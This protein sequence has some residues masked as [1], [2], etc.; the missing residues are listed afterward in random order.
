MGIAVILAATFVTTSA[1]HPAQLVQRFAWTQLLI[2]LVAGGCF[3][4]WRVAQFPKSR[5]A[6]FYL[7][8]PA[9]DWQ[10]V[11]AQIV[12]GVFRATLLVL[13][14]LPFVAGMRGAGWIGV[15]E[16]IRMIRESTA[17]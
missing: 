1:I 8:T 4:G 9:S 2:A 3:V 15:D 13:V 17:A 10:I 7:V 6:E 5:A 14:S 12:S 16:M 11:M